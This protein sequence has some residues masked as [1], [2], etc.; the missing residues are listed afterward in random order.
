MIEAFQ[1]L[2]LLH[3]LLLF[4]TAVLAGGLNAVAGGGTFFTFPILL[5]TGVPPVAANATSSV[6]V[7]PGVIASAF[8]YRDL[9]TKHKSMLPLM[10]GIGLVGGWLG[11]E[12]LLMTPDATFRDM[13]PWLLLVATALF[14]FGR[15]ITDWTSRTFSSSPKLERFRVA[16]SSLFQLIISIYGGFFGA[17]IGILMLAMLQC[18]GMKDIHDMNAFKAA[19]GAGIHGSA[20]VT[21]ILSGIIFW[22]QAIIMVAGAM[23]GGYATA[24][25]ALKMSQQ[26]VRL[27]VILVGSATT[28]YFFLQ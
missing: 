20:V 13:I 14:A 1:D 26:T 8:G 10:I 24:R 19:L 23:L 2:S 16:F 22:P 25:L 11:A 17:G 3:G 7:W 18:L 9:L 28:I 4:A 27:F 15:P 6:A 5:F 12:L 21:F